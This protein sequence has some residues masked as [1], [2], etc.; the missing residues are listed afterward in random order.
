MA[1]PNDIIFNEDKEN[2]PKGKTS[3]VYLKDFDA[4]KKT[5]VD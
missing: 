1:I 4:R 2:I 3:A 5:Q